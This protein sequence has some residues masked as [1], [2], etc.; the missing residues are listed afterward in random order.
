MLFSFTSPPPPLIIK[1]KKGE[2]KQ[3]CRNLHLLIPEA[4]E[5]KKHTHTI[6]VYQRF[7][8]ER[9]KR[10]MLLLSFSGGAVSV[11]A[12]LWWRQR[13]RQMQTQRQT[14]RKRSSGKM[15]RQRRCTVI[16][17]TSPVQ[18]NPDPLLIKTVLDSFK[19]VGGLNECPRIIVCDGCVVKEKFAKGDG[20][21]CGVVTAEGERKYDEYKLRVKKECIRPNSGDMMLE[22]P[23]RHGFGLAVKAGL[24]SVQ[25]K[26]VMIVQHDRTFTR[27]A[28]EVQL[29]NLLDL[30]DQNHG[31]LR[32]VN[33]LTKSLTNHAHRIQGRWKRNPGVAAILKY[34]T[35]HEVSDGKGLLLTPYFSF[36]DSTHVASTEHYREFMFGSPPGSWRT[37]TIDGGQS[38]IL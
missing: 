20:F 28:S 29:D 5:K 33:F 15:E 34:C 9:Q 8:G 14:Q 37:C 36:M 4:T 12:V 22:L 13:E 3:F 1:L 25:T 26:Y 10:I 35:E 32:V 16:I 6:R 27:H 23:F 38:C 24:K 31:V 2:R 11:V 21:R 17:T 30:M 18:S 7:W 19:F